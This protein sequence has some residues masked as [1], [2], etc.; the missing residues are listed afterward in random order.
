MWQSN[1]KTW[2][3]STRTSRAGQRNYGGIFEGAGLDERL[4]DIEKRIGEP[5]FWSNQADA[6]K[7]MQGR[8]RLEEDQAL[9]QSLRRRAD[10]LGVLVEWA[11]DGEAV[12]ADL[13][14]GLGEFHAEVEAAET[15][16]M[17]QTRN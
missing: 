5:D 14:R 12:S 2:S 10:D 1:S 7:V 15:K 8:R 6:Q 9:R 3:D 4:A 17:R 13:A 11:N 16:K